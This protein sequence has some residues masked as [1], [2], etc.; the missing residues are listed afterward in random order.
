MTKSFI[1]IADKDGLIPIE[2]FAKI[3]DLSKIDTYEITPYDGYL[4]IRFFD[5]DGNIVPCSTES[6]IIIP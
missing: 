3:L 6:D 5:K 4:S 1:V 2:S